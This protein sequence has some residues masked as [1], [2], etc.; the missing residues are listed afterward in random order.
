MTTQ[1]HWSCAC[2]YEQEDNCLPCTWWPGYRKYYERGTG[3]MKS[4]SRDFFSWTDD[5]VE[6][7]LSKCLTTLCIQHWYRPGS[8][9]GGLHHHFPKSQFLPVQ[10]TTQPR[11]FRTK[12]GP[13][14]FPED[15]VLG[16]IKLQ[17]SVD[18]SNSDAF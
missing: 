6:H 9:C 8:E 12:T 14:A 2:Q 4:K 7:S 5:K 1:V 11:S 16:A 18:G 15:F 10:T 13:A 3:M 17:S